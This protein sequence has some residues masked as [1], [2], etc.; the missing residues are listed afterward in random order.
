M[1]LLLTIL[2]FLVS[3]QAFLH[4]L[5]P[6]PAL[7]FQS[8]SA[9]HATV[10]AAQSQRHDIPHAWLYCADRCLYRGRPTDEWASRSAIAERLPKMP[11]RPSFISYHPLPIHSSSSVLSISAFDGSCL[12]TANMEETKRDDV[13]HM[14]N[15]SDTLVGAKADMHYH[16]KAC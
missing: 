12:A 9:F 15:A 2:F 1:Y 3:P 16:F 8:R 14:E 11:R 10:H 5:I 7:P 13:L 6:T 4:V